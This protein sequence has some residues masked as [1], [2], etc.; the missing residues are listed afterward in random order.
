MEEDELYQDLIELLPYST[1]ALQ[2][3]Q[4]KELVLE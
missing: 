2:A 3:P 1:E 4:P